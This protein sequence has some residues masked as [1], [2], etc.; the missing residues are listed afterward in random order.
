PGR[1]KLALSRMPVSPLDRSARREPRPPEGVV[2]LGRSLALPR[3]RPARREPRP[4]EG[5]SGSAGASPSR[6]GGGEG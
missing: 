2:R 1:A 4:P 3:D 6:G 5:L